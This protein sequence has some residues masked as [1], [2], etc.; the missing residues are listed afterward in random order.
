MADTPLLQAQDIRVEFPITRGLV[1]QRRVGSIG[2]VAGVSVELAATDPPACPAP[3]ITIRS[4]ATS[5][6]RSSRPPPNMT[7]ASFLCKPS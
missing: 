4:A 1:F 3:T 7:A 5:L 2:A 6:T